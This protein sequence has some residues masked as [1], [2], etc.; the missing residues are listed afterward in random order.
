MVNV[1]GGACLMIDSG[2]INMHG[3][4]GTASSPSCHGVPLYQLNTQPSSHLTP[5]LSAAPAAVS[6]ERPVT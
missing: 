4:A 6:E 5:A 3:Y 1:L 2:V